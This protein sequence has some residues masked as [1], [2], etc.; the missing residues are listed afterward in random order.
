MAAPPSPTLQMMLPNG[1]SMHQ[2]QVEL[3]HWG[4]IDHIEMLPFPI[5][6]VSVAFFDVRAATRA[7]LHLGP[8]ISQFGAPSGH[9]FAKLPGDLNLDEAEL[10]GLAG[11]KPDVKDPSSFLLEFYDTR[12]AARVRDLVDKHG[13][14]KKQAAKQSSKSIAPAISSK[15]TAAVHVEVYLTGLPNA[16]CSSD[17]MEAIF[18]QGGLASSVLKTRTK[19]GNQTGEAYVTLQGHPAAEQCLEHFNGRQW[20]A[21]GA[22]VLAVVVSV[23]AATKPCAASIACASPL[24]HH[25]IPQQEEAS[26]PKAAVK[27]PLGMMMPPGLECFGSEY[28]SSLS[29]AFEVD[30]T[31]DETSPAKLADPESSTDA[32]TSD[33]EVDREEECFIDEAHS[34]SCR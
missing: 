11:I 26:K 6:T 9:R 15:D 5:P 7:H 19:P 31:R 16:L 10:T 18:Q 17:C 21:S 23:K 29:A 12:D 14:P 1:M 3:S 22:I 34:T 25:S 33:A 20:D 13:R 32:G 30:I 24:E 8:G 28:T 4:D 2:A 27:A